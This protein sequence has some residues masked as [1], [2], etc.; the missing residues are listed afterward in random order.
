MSTDDS[1][2]V[3][4]SSAGQ[5]CALVSWSGGKDSCLAFYRAKKA[6]TYPK[7]L[8]WRR[9]MLLYITVSVMLAKSDTS[10]PSL[11]T[12]RIESRINCFA[13]WCWVHAL[14]RNMYSSSGRFYPFRPMLWRTYKKQVS[15]QYSSII[16]NQINPES[17]FMFYVWLIRCDHQIVDN[18]DGRDRWIA[19]TPHSS[20]Y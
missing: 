8:W 12:V 7:I 19:S 13:S 10:L 5:N 11:A 2:V 6:G 4:V 20:F 9:A 18:I 16:F 1:S 17:L 3:D 14:N 15:L